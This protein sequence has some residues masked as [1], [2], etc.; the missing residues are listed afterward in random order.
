MNYD[1]QLHKQMQRFTQ[2][3]VDVLKAL[4]QSFKEESAILGKTEYSAEEVLE[5]IAT[6]LKYK[7]ETNEEFIQKVKNIKLQEDKKNPKN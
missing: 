4:I 7:E 1:L 5:F 2:A 6:D 3:R